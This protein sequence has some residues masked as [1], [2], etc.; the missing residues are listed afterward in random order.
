M[1]RNIRK[2]DPEFRYAGMMRAACP[3]DGI[4]WF[5]FMTVRLLAGEI[6]KA[7]KHNH[8][9]V[10]YYPEPAE[11]LLITPQPGTMLYLP[12]GTTHEVPP[13]QRERLSIAMLIDKEK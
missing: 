10:L 9:L 7:H 12:P 8:H 1:N 5:K 4:D 2:D 3:L 13:I 6:I 11:P